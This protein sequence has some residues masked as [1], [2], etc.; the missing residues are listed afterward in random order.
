MWG[1]LT[2]KIGP[3][4]AIA[5]ATLGASVFLILTGRLATSVLTLTVLMGF[6]GSFVCGLAYP[7]ISEITSSWF[8]TTW[9]GRGSTLITAGGTAGGLLMGV[10]SGPLIAHYGWRGFLVALGVIGVACAA[11]QFILVRDKPAD[12][13]TIPF[14]S[15]PN[16]YRRELEAERLPQ[17]NGNTASSKYKR[18]HRAVVAQVLK[19]P[20]TWKFS[21]ML[22]LC[23]LIQYAQSTYLIASIREAGVMLLAAS[24]AVT[25]QFAAQFAGQIVLSSITDRFARRNVLSFCLVALGMSY[26]LCYYALQARNNVFMLVAV[27]I[28]GFFNSLSPLTNVTITEMF[29]LKLRATGPGVCSTIDSVGGFLGPLVAT[30]VITTVGRG[31]TISFL[32]YVAVVGVIAGIYCL[33]AIPKTGAGRKYGD[34]LAEVET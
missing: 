3:R 31:Q 33:I 24:L 6:M 30:A 28:T 13:G 17:E 32:P 12:I 22:V 34:P 8:D 29:P 26:V 9:R 15:D 27:G 19:L 18:E 25:V 4:M 23:D 14:G 1:R 20:I 10:T 21:V 5:S 2:D 16:E 11:I 7:T